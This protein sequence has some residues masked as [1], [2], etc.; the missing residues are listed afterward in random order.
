MIGKAGQ[1]YRAVILGAGDSGLA[2]LEMLLD[3]EELVEVVAVVDREAGAP[4]LKLAEER[5]VTICSDVEQALSQFRP[6]IAFNMTGNEMVELVASEIIGPGGIIG[7]FEAR[8]MLRMINNLKEAR[9]ELRFQ[10]IRDPLTGLYNRRHMM[11]ELT[12]AVSEALRYEHHCT[13]VMMDLDHFKSVNDTY[14]HA[15][16]DLVLSHMAR[17]LKGSV[18]DADIVARWGGEEFIVLL[19]HTHTEGA[20]RA[21]EQWLANL[22][23]APLLLEGGEAVTVSFS[24]GVAAAEWLDGNADVKIEVD[25]MLNLADARMYEA[26]ERGRC[27]VCSGE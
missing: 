7:G 9:D 20:H 26:K 24:A 3:E 12:Q 16:G 15:A 10:A 21:A 8:L 19:T 1:V 11:T 2:V 22:T 23:A 14:G 5:G 18:R 27:R 17:V 6:D 25:R 4:A 13:V